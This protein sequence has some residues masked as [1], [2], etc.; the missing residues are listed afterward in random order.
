MAGRVLG[1]E[2][3]ERGGGAGEEGVGGEEL[4]GEGGGPGCEEGDYGGDFGVDLSG[5]ENGGIN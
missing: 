2:V 5:R 4:A 1:V 3:G